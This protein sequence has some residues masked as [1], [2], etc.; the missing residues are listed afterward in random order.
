[1]NIQRKHCGSFE[2]SD[3][4]NEVLSTY[5][6]LSKYDHWVKMAQVNISP[7][8][9]LEFVS[10]FRPYEVEEETGLNAR[11]NKDILSIASKYPSITSAPKEKDTVWGLYNRINWSISRAFT[12]KDQREYI[13]INN[14]LE[15]SLLQY[16]SIN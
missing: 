10:S 1:M 5:G 4:I 13:K 14:K 9:Q 12:T 7:E 16:F 15:S 3:S 11:R 2:L 8:K 6:D